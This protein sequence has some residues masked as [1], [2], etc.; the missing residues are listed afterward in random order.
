MIDGSCRRR[1]LT[2]NGEGSALPVRASMTSISSVNFMLPL[3]SDAD[4]MMRVLHLA[5]VEKAQTMW[6]TG[7]AGL[8]ALV[9]L[10]RRGF[11]NASYAHLNRLANLAPADVLFAPHPCAPAELPDLLRD[12]KCLHQ[13]GL[14]IAQVTGELSA[15]T[16]GDLPSRLAPLGYD[17][18]RRLHEKGRTVC[19]A[20]R[21][22]RPLLSVAA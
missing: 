7:P 3:G 22:G 2:P 12:V 11:F 15:E 19:I 10:N 21:Y 14:F 20:R 6:V 1:P 4:A 8:T 16:L 18:Q 5:G 17:V 9:W 13:G